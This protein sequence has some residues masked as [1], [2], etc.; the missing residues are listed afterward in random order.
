[1][2]DKLKFKKFEATSSTKLEIETLLWALKS[3]S[4]N[5]ENIHLTIYTD[6]QC[7]IK[8]NSRREKLEKLNFKSQGKGKELNNSELYK[9]FYNFYDKLNF[10]IIKVVGHSK[11]SEKDNIDKIFSYV[12]KGSRETLKKYLNIST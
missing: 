9:K 8:L 6:C 11:F 2:Q 12:D 5:Y 1:M 4:E 7:I 3:I 10:D